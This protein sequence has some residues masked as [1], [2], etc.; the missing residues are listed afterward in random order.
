MATIAEGGPGELAEVPRPG[1]GA[2]RSWKS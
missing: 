1:C 2:E